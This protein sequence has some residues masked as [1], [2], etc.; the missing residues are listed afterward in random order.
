MKKTV[1]KRYVNGLLVVDVSDAQTE[2]VI[3]KI[4]KRNKPAKLGTA[5]RIAALKDVENERILMFPN[6]LAKGYS[7][8][9][10]M[11]IATQAVKEDRAKRRRT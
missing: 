6:P 3:A 2:A 8:A 7:D 4:V 9:Q 5:A 10:I 11:D 1:K